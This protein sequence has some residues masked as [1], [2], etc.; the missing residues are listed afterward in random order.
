MVLFYEWINIP[1]YVRKLAIP[2]SVKIYAS[3]E[4]KYLIFDD[5]PNLIVLKLVKNQNLED[6]FNTL[7]FKEIHDYGGYRFIYPTDF[8][9]AEKVVEEDI[10]KPAEWKVTKALVDVKDTDYVL[11]RLYFKELNI[12]NSVLTFDNIEYWGIHQKY[13]YLISKVHSPNPVI[14]Y[15]YL[16]IT[17]KEMYKRTCD[18]IVYPFSY[19]DYT[20]KYKIVND[21]THRHCFK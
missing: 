6:I 17:D 13:L 5:D 3:K 11:S 20:T 9:I 14:H 1:K 10:D 4:N 18:I 8:I 15:S 12:V 16:Q 21:K 7:N 19:K 2:S